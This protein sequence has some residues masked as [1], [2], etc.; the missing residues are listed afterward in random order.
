[1]LKEVKGEQN[2]IF[3]SGWFGFDTLCDFS[4]INWHCDLVVLF[5]H[6]NILEA[7]IQW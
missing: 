1:M 2:P 4:G 5:L 6:S 7:N 3:L